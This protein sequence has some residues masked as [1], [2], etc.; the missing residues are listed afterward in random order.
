MTAFVTQTVI[1]P[2]AMETKGTVK[3]FAFAQ[4]HGLMM[5]RV[6][7]CAITAI[8]ATMVGIASK[9]S[10][11]LGVDLK[12]WE[13]GYVIISVIQNYAIRTKEIAK[14]FQSARAAQFFKATECVMINATFWSACTTMEIVHSRLL[15]AVVLR[16]A[17]LL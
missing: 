15:R 16:R 3:T 11:A 4:N 17:H 2:S 13:M 10:A 6:I 1:L 9:R 8:V 5:A 14:A 7:T 12:C